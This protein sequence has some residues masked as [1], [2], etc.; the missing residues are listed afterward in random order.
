MKPA[1]WCETFF[2]NALNLRMSQIFFLLFF[3]TYPCKT[4]KNDIQK[5]DHFPSA[6]KPH[7][8][9]IDIPWYIKSHVFEKSPLP[10]I[11]C[12]FTLLTIIEH[13][14]SIFHQKKIDKFTILHRIFVFF[15]NFFKITIC[16]P[17]VIYQNCV[18]N[19]L[20]KYFFYFP[21]K[22]PYIEQI[23]WKKTHV[24]K[25]TADFE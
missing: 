2:E 14:F 17:H 12:D 18:I 1:F 7:T 5:N 25:Y 24:V 20:A 6:Y 13:V 3:E 21:A 10:A 15:W 19:T 8:K 9:N 11:L 4:K 23:L 16:K 22:S